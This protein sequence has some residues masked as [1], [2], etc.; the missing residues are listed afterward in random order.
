MPYLVSIPSAV[1]WRIDKHKHDR[2][3]QDTADDEGA[4]VAPGHL[5]VEAW[6]IAC[7]LVDVITKPKK[8]YHDILLLQRLPENGI[9]YLFHNLCN[10][11]FTVH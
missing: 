11:R 1:S 10:R 4:N 9:P 2:R 7:H 6:T 5:P 3:Q 8:K